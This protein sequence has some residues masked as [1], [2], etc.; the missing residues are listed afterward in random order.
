[1]LELFPEVRSQIIENT[2]RSDQKGDSRMKVQGYARVTIVGFVLLLAAMPALAGGP[3][4]PRSGKAEAQQLIDQAWEL[5]HT[6]STA[7]IYKQ[8]VSWMEQADQMDPNNDTILTDLARYRWNYGDNLPKQTKEEQTKIEGIYAQGL[9]A[10]EKSMAVK[11]TVAGHYWYAVN[12]AAGLE[13]S[14]IFSQ[15]AGFPTILKHSGYVSDH[16]PDYYYGASG[17]L[18]S[19]ILV[20]VPKIV[21]KMV[22]YDPQLVVDD[23][24]ASIQKEPRYLD[25][26]VYKARFI[27]TY[28]ENKDEA[29]A[30]LDHALKQDPAVLPEEVSA[31]RVAQ[32]D[33]RELWK[34]ITGKDYPAK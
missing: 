17:R 13:F 7:E 20:R 6:D 15:A 1:M 4:K 5:S 9:A 34:K 31:N 29:L 2:F 28:F 27:Y 19:E 14:T 10:A 22:G 30:L 12:K 3:P 8:C 21:V 16:E 18:W 23:I 26:Y 32:R 24:N 33:A 11:E 25:N